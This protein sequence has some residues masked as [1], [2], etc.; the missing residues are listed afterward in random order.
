MSAQGTSHV[1]LPAELWEKVFVQASGG[2]SD[3]ATALALTNKQANEVATKD[4]WSSPHLPT[5]ATIE[6][7]LAAIESKPELKTLIKSLRVEDRK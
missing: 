4:I 3:A 1:S 6:S 7:F 2:G 5:T